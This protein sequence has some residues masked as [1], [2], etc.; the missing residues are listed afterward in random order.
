MNK[1]SRLQTVFVNAITWTIVLLVSFPLIWMVL[2]AVKP[3]SEL[4]R[5]PPTFLPQ[6]MTF[7]HYARLLFDTPF[8][9]YFGNSVILAM[10]TTILVIAVGTLGA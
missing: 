6:R 8:P 3:Q 5:I 7:E 1:P 2:T 4:F 9:T 10:A